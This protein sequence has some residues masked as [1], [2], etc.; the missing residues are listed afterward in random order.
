MLVRLERVDLANDDV[1]AELESLLEK[2]K[3]GDIRQ[4]AIAATMDGRDVLTS[5]VCQYDAFQLIGATQYLQTR[6]VEMIE[7]E[8]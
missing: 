2:A 8:Q 1:V 4:I 6:I 7:R 5:I 3:R